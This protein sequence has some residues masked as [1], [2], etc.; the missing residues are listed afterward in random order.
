M[1]CELGYFFVGTATLYNTDVCLG[2]YLKLESIIIG[3]FLQAHHFGWYSF[4]C[5]LRP[6]VFHCWVVLDL[7]DH[8]EFELGIPNQRPEIV[9]LVIASSFKVEVYLVFNL[10]GMGMSIWNR[11]LK[12]FIMIFTSYWSMCSLKAI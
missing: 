6:I 12:I 11:C 5:F 8:I 3:L 4:S 1:S 10:L 2:I 7:T 9:L